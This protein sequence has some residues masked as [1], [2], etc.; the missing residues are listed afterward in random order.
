MKKISLVATILCSAIVLTGAAATYGQARPQVMAVGSSGAFPTMAIAAV[1]ADP[2]TGQA[3]P[4]GTNFW[5]GGG[6]VSGV[7]MAAGIDNRQG[8]AI[9]AE[10]GNIWIAWDNSTTPTVVCAYLSVDS[11]VGLRLFFSQATNGGI[12][13]NGYISLNSAATTTGGACKVAFVNDTGATCPG[14][15]GNPLPAA[16]YNVVNGANFN[17]GFSDIRPEDGINGNTRALQS[18]SNVACSLPAQCFGYVFGLTTSGQYA[19]VESS[20]TAGNNAY[21]VPFSIPPG[22]VPGSTSQGSSV[23]VNGITVTMGVDPITSMTIPAATTINV[24]AYPELVFVN[25]TGTSTGSFKNQNPTNIDSH[26]LSQIYAGLGGQVAD[27]TGQTNSTGSGV[28]SFAPLAVM[29]REPT[30]GTY[31]TF[32]WQVVRDRDAYYGNSQETLN[33]GQTAVGCFTPP[34]T[35]TYVPPTTACYDPLY[36]PNGFDGSAFHA[37]VVGSSEMV[38][39]VNSANNP[40]SI[41]YSFWSLGSFGGKTNLKYLTVDGVDPIQTEYSSNNGASPT[42]TGFFNVS[43]ITCTG[44]TLPTFAHIKDGSYRLFNIIRAV[45]DNSVQSYQTTTL[46]K[47]MNPQILIQFTQNQAAATTHDVVP[48]Q[49]C[50]TYNTSTGAFTGCGPVLNVFRSHYG[51]AG[52]YPNNGILGAY[53]AA[54]SITPVPE[55]G[56]DVQGAV[57][58]WAAELDYVNYFGPDF[59]FYNV[60]Q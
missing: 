39:A 18:R 55:G 33:L 23:T 47:V 38:A 28:G 2:I 15:A 43:G 29:S 13:T 7:P 56:G 35:A 54:N 8:T 27:V 41:G 50:S 53:Y 44:Y 46:T 51:M 60:I 40:D 42:C 12:Q 37:R 3:A 59:E 4:C 34:S 1:T 20:Y 49:T 25:M 26:E 52:V 10:P 6:N 32:E 31:N 36:A 22:G 45:V 58:P 14:T 17:A 30:S 57:L 19:A 11:I 9:A 24:G 48:I 16:I 5:S 21:V